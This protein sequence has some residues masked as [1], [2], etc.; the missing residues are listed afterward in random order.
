MLMVKIAKKNAIRTE[1]H[2]PHRS[3]GVSMLVM[4]NIIHSGYQYRS[5]V[6]MI[7]F[8]RQILVSLDPST[9]AS[10]VEISRQI[11]IITDMPC[12][13]VRKESYFSQSFSQAL[14]EICS[15][16]LSLVIEK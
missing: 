14:V 11:R 8:L 13:V 12:Q 9:Q 4:T 2:F 16:K 3:I 10:L 6:I 1:D 5:V 15:L 7:D